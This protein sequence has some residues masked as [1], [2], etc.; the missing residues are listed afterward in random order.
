MPPSDVNAAQN[1]DPLVKGD[2]ETWEDYAHRLEVRIKAQRDHIHNLTELRNV[3]GDIKARK[4]IADLE[5]ALG[6]M[7]L[8]LEREVENREALVARLEEAS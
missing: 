5:R 8:R 6:K 7:A 1:D 4:R 3:P 2:G